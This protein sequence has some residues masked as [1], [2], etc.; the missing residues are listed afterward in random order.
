MKIEL[1]A[2]PFQSKS[3]GDVKR[4]RKQGK[5]PAVLYGHKEKTKSFYIEMKDFK[6]VLELMQEEMVLVNLKLEGKKH[7][8]V[9]KSIQHN[10]I[11]SNLLHIDFQHIHKKEKIKTS[12]PIHL[13]GEAKGIKKGGILDQNLHEVTLR[14]LPDQLPAH[15]DVDVSELDLG[16]TIHLKDLPYKDLEFEL[17]PDTPVVSV[18]EPKVVEEPKAEVVEAGAE[19]KKISEEEKAAEEKSEGKET[20]EKTGKEK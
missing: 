10:P 18:L 20:K 8:C 14:C 17:T 1:Q 19:V 11:T 6:E 2:F 4:L 3:K 7:L 5:I 16:E 13:I 12:I 9:I 15:I